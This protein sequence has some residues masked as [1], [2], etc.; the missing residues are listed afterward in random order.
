MD[1]KRELKREYKETKVTAGIFQ[2]RNLKNGK[3]FLETTP[4]LKTVN[5]QLFMLGMKSH[6][7]KQLQ[8][9]WNE[10]GETSFVIETL[11]IVDEEQNIDTKTALKRLL[12]KWTEKLSPYGE[13][14]Y[15]KIKETT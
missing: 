9:E 7:N 3:V 1:R 8:Q 5:G 11:E 10:M 13:K 4:N 14:G 15:H 6:P 12:D 2:I